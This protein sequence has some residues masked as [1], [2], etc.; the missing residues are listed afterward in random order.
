VSMRGKQG[1]GGPGGRE[2]EKRAGNLP[3]CRK[4]AN[5]EGFANPCGSGKWKG[6]EDE[7]K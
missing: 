1:H 7:I 6:K 2:G 5:E 4:G 3:P